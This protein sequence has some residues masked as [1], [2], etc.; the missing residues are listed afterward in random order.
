MFLIKKNFKSTA[1][2]SLY[3]NLCRCY[4]GHLETNRVPKNLYNKHF[5]SFSV[6]NS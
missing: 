2:C 6:A 3:D 4:I 1:A 5:S